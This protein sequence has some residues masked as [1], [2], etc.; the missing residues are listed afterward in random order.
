MTSKLATEFPELFD[1]IDDGNFSI[2]YI[3]NKRHFGMTLRGSEVIQ[4]IFYCPW[5]GRKLP[6]SLWDTFFDELESIGVDPMEDDI[7][8]EYISEAWWINQDL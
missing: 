6:N 5:T 1:H 4:Q 2:V 7:P 8:E 3:P